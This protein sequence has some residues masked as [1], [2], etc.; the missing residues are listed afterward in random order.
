M[1]I[2]VVVDRFMK[3]RHMIPIKSINAISVAEC[4]VKHV[5]KLYRLPN[6]IIS[7]CGS[8]FVLDF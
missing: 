8:Q 1:N 5:F 6:L 4:F 7:D 2:I 3:M